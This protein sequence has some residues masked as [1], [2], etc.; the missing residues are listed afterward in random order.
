MM[1]NQIEQLQNRSKRI[2]VAVV[3]PALNEE[4]GIGAIIDNVRKSLGDRE[5]VIIVVDGHSSDKTREIAKEKGATV[6]FQRE[7]GYGDGLLSGFDYAAS[8]FAPSI[9]TM[10]DGDGTYDPNDIPR[11]LEPIINN[12]ADLVSGDRLDN[13][14]P[15]AMS[16]TNRIGNR[17][18]SSLSRRFLG[19]RLKDTQCGLR[20]FRTELAFNFTGQADGMAFATEMLVDAKQARARMMEVPITYGPRVGKTKLN[21]IKDGSRILGIILRLVRD[22][23][24][25]LFFGSIGSILVL[26]GLVSGSSVVVEWIRTGTVTRIPTA[27]LT[28]LFVLIGVQFFSLGL[29]ADMIK[30]FRTRRLRF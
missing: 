25:L 28:A 26:L 22:Y 10:I 6:I 12:E 3:I 7:R 8:T 21:P 11:I 2:E 5:F 14:L 16:F 29:V 15:K 24:P 27:I 1:Y 23:K 30:S 4:E 19:L 18:I 17:I 9:I 13:L 20:A